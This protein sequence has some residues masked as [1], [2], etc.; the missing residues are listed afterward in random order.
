MF[1][2]YNK[3]NGKT[4]ESLRRK[5]IGPVKWQPVASYRVVSDCQA[6]TGLAVFVSQGVIIMI[7]T[8]SSIQLMRMDSHQPECREGA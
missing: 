1:K 7:F 3:K 8:I 4:D 2:S 6:C 5:A